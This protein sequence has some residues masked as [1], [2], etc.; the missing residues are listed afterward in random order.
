[1]NRATI[2]NGYIVKPIK[3]DTLLEKLSSALSLQWVYEPKSMDQKE[4]H[5]QLTLPLEGLPSSDKI[6]TLIELAEIGHL[7]GLKNYIQDMKVNDSVSSEFID[8]MQ[9]WIN[10]VNFDALL[11]AL[12][13]SLNKS[14][15]TNLEPAISKI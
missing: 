1:M 4:R 8:I 12:K 14:N 9:H 5:H 6:Q 13:G 11:K 10:D 7:T 15:Q 3:V 2:S